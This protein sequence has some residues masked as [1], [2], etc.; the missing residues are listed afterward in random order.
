MITKWRI[1]ESNGILG[2]HLGWRSFILDLTEKS[3]WFSDK[4]E[5]EHDLNINKYSPCLIRV[6]TQIISWNSRGLLGRFKVFGEI[7]F[8]FFMKIDP[9]KIKNPKNS[10]ISEI[11]KIMNFYHAKLVRTRSQI[12]PINSRLFFRLNPHIQGFF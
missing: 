5:S 8:K 11:S 1:F 3:D 12:L 7:K 2:E 4:K 9:H 6:A 10:E